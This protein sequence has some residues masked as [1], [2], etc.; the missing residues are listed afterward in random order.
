MNARLFLAAAFVSVLAS[1]QTLTTCQAARHYGRKAEAKACYARLAA[2]SDPYLRAEGLWAERA[3]KAANDAFRAAVQAQP[4]NADYRVRWGRMYLDHYQAQDA[5]ALFQEALGIKKDFAPAL[6]GLALIAAGN[7]EQKAAELAHQALKSD[8]NLVEAQELL[9]RVALEDNNEELAAREADK[10]IAMSPEAID[11]MSIKASIDLLND[12]E[13]SPWFD[14]IAKVNPAYG[15]AW[16]TAGHF[17]VINR[18]YDE[19]IAAY[20]K[21]IAIDP[22]LWDARG[23]LGVNLMRMG[24]D[25]ESRKILVECYNAGDTSPAVR[26]TLNLLDQY[27]KYDTF[28][29]PTT[30][31]RIHKKESAVLRP[32]VEAE[33][34]RAI[35]TYEKKYRTHVSRPIQIELYPNHEDFAVRTMGMPGLGALGVTFGTVVA[36]D[37]PSARPPGTNHW[38]STMWHELSHVYV[39]TATK[40]RVPRWFTEGMAVHEETATSP[41]WGDRLTP[42]IIKA[43]ADKKLLPVA[44]LDRGFIHPSFPSQVIISYFQGGKICDFINDKWGYDKL[45][46]MMHAFGAKK[47]TPEVFEQVLGMKTEEFDKQFFAWLDTKV[48]TTVKSYDEWHKRVRDVAKALEAKDWDGALKQGAAIRDLYP[49]YVE[50]HSVYE[51][52]AD[53]S[54]GKGDKRSAIVQLQAYA[55]Q[56][57]RTPATLKKL[58]GLQEEAGDKNGAAAT[59]AR[60]NYIY[61]QDEELHRRLGALYLENGNPAAA[62]REYQ[63]LVAGKPLDQ[64]DSNYRLALAFK[65]AGRKDDAR[66]AVINAL[67]AA[68]GY[69]AAQRL[70]LELD[71]KD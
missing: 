67:E 32:Y 70:L 1:A 8:P 42:D 12:V 20:R 33:L 64:A 4:Q 23:E 3:F 65:A 10:A 57:G 38:A 18:R 35:A 24:E 59:L 52:M 15:D 2:S 29:T 21:A 53:A 30:I 47:A 31:V 16:A 25:V 66:D 37:S 17:F 51:M 56:G 19:G 45:L 13:K 50:S 62:V 55:K 34:L 41:D 58:A 27:P 68:P 26:N 71:G 54:L 39:L 11:A 14:R 6:L 46:A 61:P 63:V 60:I 36:M 40:H 43:I 28:K 49:D 5:G 9:A 48:G 22:D 69:K 44:T 7:W